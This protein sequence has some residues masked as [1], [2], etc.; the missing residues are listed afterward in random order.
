MPAA[1]PGEEES[2]GSLL[3]PEVMV[4]NVAEDWL[5]LL[6]DVPSYLEHP[7]AIRLGTLAH[8]VLPQLSLPLAWPTPPPPRPSHP[9][10]IGPKA[11]DLPHFLNCAFRRKVSR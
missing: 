5:R 3:A 9:G 6:F 11:Q 7:L 2:C 8:F 1:A 4:R 10:A